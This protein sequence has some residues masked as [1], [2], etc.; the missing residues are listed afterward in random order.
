MRVA[1]HQQVRAHIQKATGVA[2]RCQMVRGRELIGAARGVLT[3]ISIGQ[4]RRAI[5]SSGII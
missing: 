4:E 1:G 2:N 3:S 5:S